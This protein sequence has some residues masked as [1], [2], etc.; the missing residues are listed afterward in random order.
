[1]RLT[2]KPGFNPVWSRPDS[3]TPA[4]CS[5]CQGPLPE[6]PLMLWNEQRFAISLCLACAERWIVLER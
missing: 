6:V 1:M 2:F 4:I 5:C 3:P